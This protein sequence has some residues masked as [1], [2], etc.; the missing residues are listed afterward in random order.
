MTLPPTEPIIIVSADD[1]FMTVPQVAKIF[2]VTP[3]TV[4]GWCK[5]GKVRGVK[6]GKQWRIQASTV[7]A[8][9]QK[10]YG[11]SE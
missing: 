11:D 5:D 10:M 3:Y 9:A 8:F 1:P 6:V 7:Q 4:R 2:A